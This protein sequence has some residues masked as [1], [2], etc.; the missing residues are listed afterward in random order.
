[1]RLLYDIYESG[2][3]TKDEYRVYFSDSRFYIEDG[4]I[5]ESGVGYINPETGLPDD[6]KVATL[7]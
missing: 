1:M 5:W 6:Y 7:I 2:I 3:C 4:I